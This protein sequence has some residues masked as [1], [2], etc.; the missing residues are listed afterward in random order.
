M[1]EAALE[2]P[3]E[4][5][6]GLFCHYAGQCQQS[7]DVGKGHQG[8]EYISNGPHGGYRQVRADK[9]SGDIQPPV[10]F[11]DGFVGCL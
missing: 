9:D 6:T 2:I 8:V 7:D 1:Q 5:G 10:A 3:V 11:D 4:I